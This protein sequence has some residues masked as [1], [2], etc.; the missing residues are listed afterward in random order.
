MQPMVMAFPPLHSSLPVLRVIW[1]KIKWLFGMGRV[2]DA[3]VLAHV[4]SVGSWSLQE[5]LA[6]LIAALGCLY[7]LPS[8]P[9]GGYCYG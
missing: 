3:A 9:I 1:L 5:T 2:C 8:T 7:I 6:G 4:P